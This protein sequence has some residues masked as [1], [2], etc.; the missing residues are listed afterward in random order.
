MR[1]DKR[2]IAALVSGGIESA[3]M[4]ATLSARGRVQSLYIRGGHQWEAVELYWLRRLLRTLRSPNLLPLVV[5]DMPVRDS[6]R[7]AGWSL[8]GRHVPSGK[9]R[10]EAVYLPGRNI[11][12]LSKAAVFCAERGI[13]RLAIGTLGSN[14]FPDASAGFHRRFAKVLAEGLAKPISIERPFDKLHK[15]EVIQRTHDV[16]WEM[17]FSCI[18]PRSLR[19]CGRCNKCAE[20]KK[21]FRAADVADPTRYA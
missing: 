2:T 7:H 17:T 20:R 21:A 15:D 6:Y 10:D 4:L 13:P 12:L 14:P 9:T 19:H 16:P 18:A 1:N 3:A 5:L 11:L 8:S